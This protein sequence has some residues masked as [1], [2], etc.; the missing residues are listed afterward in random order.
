MLNVMVFEP[1][2]DERSV[3][4]ASSVRVAL[5]GARAIRAAMPP[6]LHLGARIAIFQG[7]YLLVSWRSVAD[8]D[9]RCV[10]W[11]RVRPGQKGARRVAA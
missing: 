5:S 10:R 4:A 2:S 9:G 3:L 11:Q 1:K 8:R 6:A 7:A